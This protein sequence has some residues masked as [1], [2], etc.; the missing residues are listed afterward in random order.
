[1]GLENGAVSILCSP[2]MDGLKKKLDK[3][4]CRGSRRLEVPV[5]VMVAE[6]FPK[7]LQSHVPVTDWTSN[8]VLFLGGVRP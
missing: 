8:A 2:S 5:Q 1:M 6:E 4:S 3:T 7:P